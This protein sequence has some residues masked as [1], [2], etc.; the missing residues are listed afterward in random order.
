VENRSYQILLIEDDEDDYVMIRDLIREMKEPGLSLDWSSSFDTGK[1]KILKG[2]Y[3]VCLV[4]YR[5][6]AHTGLDLMRAAIAGNVIVPIILLT[7]YGDQEVEREA[8]R[9]GAADYLVKGDLTPK[10]LER[11]I[12][13]SLYRGETQAQILRQDRL[14]SVGLL[15]SG[16]AHEIGTPLGVVRGR[17]EYALMHVDDRPSVEKNLNIIVSE[18]D[19]ISKL[20]RS[21]L[22]LA[23]GGNSGSLGDISLPTVVGDVLNLMSHEFRKNEI[24]VQSALPD[25]IPLIVRAESESLHQ[26]ILNLLVNSVQAIETAVQKGRAGPHQIHLDATSEKDRWVF[27][28]RDTGC[29]ISPNNLKRLFKPFF[30]TKDIGVG[31]GLGLATSYNILKSWGGEISVESQEGVGTTFWLFLPR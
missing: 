12:R 11:S 7:G 6:G 4:D 25:E 1:E 22:N 18:I 2:S 10:L 24:S 29:G 8:M 23:R 27:S 16:L 26:V 13:Y 21:L 5:L 17:A 3:D 19:R 28:I 30:T 15:A 14:A 31:T 9:I 20:I